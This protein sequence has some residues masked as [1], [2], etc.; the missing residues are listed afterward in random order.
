MS[1]EGKRQ[2]LVLLAGVVG[3]WIFALWTFITIL[4]NG[5]TG[6][7]MVSIVLMLG[8]IL[9]APLVGWTLLEEAYSRITLDDAGITYS[10]TGGI[11]LMYAWNDVT[12]FE[13]KARGGRIARFFLGNGSGAT[14]TDHVRHADAD[15]FIEQQSEDEPPTL[16]LRVSRDHT[17]LIANPVVR[18]LHKQAHGSSIPIYSGLEN[19]SALAGAIALRLEQR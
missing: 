13:P 12:G 6:V 10:T 15:T 9:V 18:F 1:G 8:I 3:I 2:A 19:R 5:I 14:T 11:R 7:E 4:E 16:L 17:A